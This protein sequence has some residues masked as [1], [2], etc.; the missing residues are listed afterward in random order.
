MA[1]WRSRFSFVARAEAEARL[2]TRQV[3]TLADMREGLDDPVFTRRIAGLAVLQGFACPEGIC[4]VFMCMNMDVAPRTGAQRSR[5]ENNWCDKQAANFQNT[6]VLLR[7][8]AAERH[9]RLCFGTTR[10]LVA[11]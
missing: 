1:L 11:S 5:R 4:K 2:Y 8:K 10:R 3:M 7:T 6:P 9:T